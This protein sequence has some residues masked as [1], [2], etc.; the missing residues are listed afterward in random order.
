M[1]ISMKQVVVDSNVKGSDGAI[2]KLHDALFNGKTWKVRYLIVDT[3]SWL[4]ETKQLFSPQ[5]LTSTS[6]PNRSV[7][8]DATRQQFRSSPGVLSDR[9]ISRQMEEELAKHFAWSLY[10]AAGIGVGKADHREAR[11]ASTNREETL[12]ERAEDLRSFNEVT[13]YHIAAEDGDVGR[14]DDLLIDDETWNVRFL[15]VRTGTWFSNKHALISPEWVESI[16]WSERAVHVDLSRETI[17]ER[18][19]FDP[20]IPINSEVEE[21][22]YDAYARERERRPVEVLEGKPP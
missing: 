14:V 6:W 4:S 10:W 8:V 7:T 12:L 18:L 20:S 11:A 3:G 21:H 22:L 17:K 2:G 16:R 15:I 5:G 19:E 1:L 9:P 13:G